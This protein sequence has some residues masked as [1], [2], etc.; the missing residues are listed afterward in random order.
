MAN[1]NR[2]LWMQQWT[3]KLYYHFVISWMTISFLR[4]IMSHKLV[5]YDSLPS[6]LLCTLR[7]KKFPSEVETNTRE[8]LI[9]YQWHPSSWYVK[10]LLSVKSVLKTDNTRNQPFLEQQSQPA[11]TV[12][13]APTLWLLAWGLYMNPRSSHSLQAWSLSLLLWIYSTFPDKEQ[14]HIHKELKKVYGG[15]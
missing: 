14:I 4:R 11:V 1:I 15:N 2:L 3:S 7:I 13:S 6:C 5:N 10:W 8:D 9:Y 12:T